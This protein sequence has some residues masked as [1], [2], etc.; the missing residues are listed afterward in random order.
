ML[1]STSQGTVDFVNLISGSREGGEDGEG[2]RSVIVL[3]VSRDELAGCW[4]G[5]GGRGCRRLGVRLTGEPAR[6][7]CGCLVTVLSR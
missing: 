7:G 1:I 3:P 2:C 5:N 4:G 6:L